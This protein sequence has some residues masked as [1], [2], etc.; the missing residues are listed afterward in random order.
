MFDTLL[1]SRHHPLGLP[2]WG[3][4]VALALHAAVVG[5]VLRPSPPPPEQRVWRGIEIPSIVE[6]SNP[7]RVQL[8]GPVVPGGVL[9]DVPPI[10]IP[11]PIVGVRGVDVP[12][13]GLP[14]PGVPI[15]PVP[16]VGG[17][18]DPVPASLVQELPELLTAPVPPYPPLLRDAGVTGLVLVQAV[19]DTMGRPEAGS[20][21]VVQSSNASFDAAALA[22]IRGALFRPGRIW[23][24]AVRVLVRVPVEFRLQ[25]PS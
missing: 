22:T 5:A 17:G 16:G 11:G 8:P 10:P 13:I 14:G 21:Q 19:V 20:L 18:S 24:R 23:G 1:E 9:I 4:G 25:P 15:P 7:P 3:V 12:P 2:R 6:P